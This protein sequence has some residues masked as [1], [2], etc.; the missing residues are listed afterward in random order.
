MGEICLSRKFG[1]PGQID[2]FER[3]WLTFADIQGKSS[4]SLNGSLLGAAA[5]SCEFDVTSHL[6][7]HNRLEIVMPAGESGLVGEVALE[8]RTAVVLHNL[9]LIRTGKE[10]A[11]TGDLVGCWPEPFDLYFFLNDD[12]VHYLSLQT[13]GDITPFRAILGEIGELAKVRVDLIQGPSL[14]SRIIV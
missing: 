12:E 10:I 9:Q 5:G 13:S 4:I 7:P 6:K 14:W 11:V 1:Y 8:V 3:V 2:S